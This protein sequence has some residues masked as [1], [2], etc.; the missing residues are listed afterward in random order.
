VTTGAKQTLPTGPLLP[1][2]PILPTLPPAPV[3]T[4][5]APAQA[6]AP[7]AANAADT[8]QPMKVGVLQQEADTFAKP[9][10]RSSVDKA[11]AKAT[12]PSGPVS[13]PEI[14]LGAGLPPRT[15]TYRRDEILTGT[16]SPEARARVINLGYDLR[17][18][19][20]SGLT[21]IILPPLREAWETAHGLAEEFPKE[22]FALNYFYQPY[23][24]VLGDAPIE[25][26]VPVSPY[27]GCS[28]ERC[29]G[30]RV[31]GWQDQLSA[32]AKGVKVG[33]I[34][35]GFDASHPTFAKRAVMP[36][37]VMRAEDP[38]ARAPDW[39]GTG[40]LSLLAGAATSSTP[41]LI[42][43]ADFLVADAFFANS[44]GRPQTDTVHLL[45]ALQRLAENGAQIVNMSLV[46]PPDDVLHDRIAYLSKRKGMVFIAAAGNGGRDAPPGYPAA[47]R[48][49]I[50]VTAVDSNGRGYRDA[51]HGGYISVAAPGV[52]IWTALPGNKEGM[53]S[54][55]SFAVPFVTAITAVTY[56]KSQL[57][58]MIAARHRG[59]DP[60]GI[61]LAGFTV[62]KIED[63]DAR[64]QRET[65]GRGL[66]KAPA[67][68][69]PKELPWTAKVEPGLTA[70]AAWLTNVRRASYQ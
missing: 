66:V 68:C 51:N 33:V 40:V 53:L 52:R 9:Q 42:P 1:I 61:T 31:I 12:L 3:S 22:G 60:K 38:G 43:D 65:Y 45:E 21:R 47:Y 24:Y 39:H 55:T 8:D 4:P 41:G 13:K 11:R 16:L 23:E 5:A 69:S 49:V 7:T 28:T 17:E 44:A 14:A 6:W 50:A 27:P 58:T 59:L 20:A 26:S 62:D 10:V 32:C 36:T 63:G 54:G 18:G 64:Q 29:Y 48:E 56:N 67:D 30:R 2:Q 37:V 34:D 46:G 25:A 70:P 15:G 57:K 19:S 35:T